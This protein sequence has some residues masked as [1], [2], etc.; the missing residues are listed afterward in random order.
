MCAAI[1]VTTIE[2]GTGG[3]VVPDRVEARV[4]YRYAPD[5][6]P[7]EAEGWLRDLLAHPK[8][9]LEVLGNAPPGPVAV[10]NPLVTRLREA[11]DL[12]VGP[13]QAWTPVAEFAM[14]GI[15]A[16]N[17]GPGHPRYAHRDDERVDVDALV[18]SYQVLR[19]FLTGTRD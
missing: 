6:R 9:Q 11:G 18:R 5:R 17:F 4:N 2:G 10:R 3:N 13:K 16:V 19:A 7:S 14:A 8:A 12:S 1:G 15:D